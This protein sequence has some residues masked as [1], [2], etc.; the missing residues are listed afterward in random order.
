MVNDEDKILNFI[1]LYVYVEEGWLL[2]I[3][4]IKVVF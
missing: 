1:K 2:Y 3:I 4:I